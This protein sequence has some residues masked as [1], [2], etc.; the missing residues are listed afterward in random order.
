MCRE[1]FEYSAYPRKHPYGERAPV[2]RYLGR[3]VGREEPTKGLQYYLDHPIELLNIRHEI[4][5][6]PFLSEQARKQYTLHIMQGSEYICTYLVRQ[7]GNV[8]EVIH[9]A[10]IPQDKERGMG[11]RD[12][13]YY[14]FD[15]QGRFVDSKNVEYNTGERKL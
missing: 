7:D 13:R 1:P 10:D 15:S 14:Y 12:E 6:E 3:D 4:R 9:E 5:H 2:G 8:I 11:A